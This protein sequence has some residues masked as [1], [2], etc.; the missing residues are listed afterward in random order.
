MTFLGR[1]NRQNVVVAAGGGASLP[2]RQARESSPPSHFPAER[3]RLRSRAAR[4]TRA[5]GRELAGTG[6]VPPG[7]GQG[8]RR[9]AVRQLPRLSTVSAAR[10]HRNGLETDH[11]RYAGARPGNSVRFGA[12]A[13]AS[14]FG[15]VDVNTADQQSS[16]VLDLTS[17]QAAAIIEYWTHEGASGV[18]RSLRNVPKASEFEVATPARAPSS[19]PVRRSTAPRPRSEFERYDDIRMS[20]G[21]AGC[22]CWRAPSWLGRRPAR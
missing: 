2:L 18:R 10:L 22:C 1:D 7:E 4:G 12:R 15:R 16:Q 17:R 19:S 21:V 8:Q 9:P 6:E 20:R 5:W 13:Y 11:R 14:E 3:V